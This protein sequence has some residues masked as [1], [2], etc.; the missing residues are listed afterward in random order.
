MGVS[1]TA[2]AVAASFCKNLSV[3]VRG[4]NP[5]QKWTVGRVAGRVEK[6]KG[7]QLYNV[8]LPR[9]WYCTAS[10]GSTAPVHY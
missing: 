2:V 6:V 10:A 1:F 5:W 8:N 3:I 4:T 9:N 7:K